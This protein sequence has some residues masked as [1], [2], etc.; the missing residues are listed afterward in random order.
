TE[1]FGQM[2]RA[3]NL[4]E[5][6][7]SSTCEYCLVALNSPSKISTEMPP[8]LSARFFT[9]SKIAWLKPFWLEAARKATR[10]SFAAAGPAIVASPTLAAKVMESFTNFPD[11]LVPLAVPGDRARRS[12]IV[13]TSCRQG[14]ILPHQGRLFESNSRPAL[15]GK[16]ASGEA[17]SR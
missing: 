8:I 15:A 12:P 3:S 10:N 1:S 5:V 2:I 6:V 9:P 14:P 7:T 11:I 16:G 13:H 4:P 17:A